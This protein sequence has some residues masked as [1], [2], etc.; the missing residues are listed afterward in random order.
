M[1]IPSGKARVVGSIKG[2]EDQGFPG[3]PEVDHPLQ[4]VG[5]PIGEVINV[6]NIP[7]Y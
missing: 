2:K 1:L 6:P 4:G 7:P 3:T 5:V